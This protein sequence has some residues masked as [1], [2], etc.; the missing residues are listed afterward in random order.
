MFAF[1]IN[2]K[3]NISECMLV[4]DLLLEKDLVG[5]ILEFIKMYEVVVP[6]PC[7]CGLVALTWALNASTSSE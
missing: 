5:I 6:N 4:S 3:A 2:F 7:L 1:Y